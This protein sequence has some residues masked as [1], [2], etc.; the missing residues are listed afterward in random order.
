MTIIKQ[1]SKFNWLCMIFLSLT[2]NSCSSPVNIVKQSSNCML[3]SM[4]ISEF[5]LS[6]IN[7]EVANSEMKNFFESNYKYDV[8]YYK[9]RSGESDYVINRWYYKSSD[10]FV[11]IEIVN[12]KKS[13]T[14]INIMENDLKILF[15]KLESQSYNK[16]CGGCYGCANGLL[17]IRNK[18]LFFKYHYVGSFHEDLNQTEKDKIISSIDILNFLK[19]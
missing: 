8:I 9:G 5:K 6:H 19:S 17:L 7:T 12:E 14:E 3:I 15:Q 2:I 1:I 13:I 10:V 11:H 16:D 4:D 18:E